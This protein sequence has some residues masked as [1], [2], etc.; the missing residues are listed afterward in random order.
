MRARIKT[1]NNP[2]AYRRDHRDERQ[3]EARMKRA[4]D[5]ELL[6]RLSKPLFDGK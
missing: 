3:S 6:K 1:S 4:R 2:N 5:Q